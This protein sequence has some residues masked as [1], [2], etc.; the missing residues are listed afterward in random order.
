MVTL[1]YAVKKYEANGHYKSMGMWREQM[2]EGSTQSL[3]GEG[4]VQQAE[5]L[6]F[7]LEVSQKR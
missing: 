7:S 5:S 4:N 3:S 6:H 1:L 2:R